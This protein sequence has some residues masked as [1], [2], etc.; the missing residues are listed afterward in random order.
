MDDYTE[1]TPEEREAGRQMML[2]TYAMV[3]ALMAA[4]SDAVM[5]AETEEELYDILNSFIQEQIND[6]TN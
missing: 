1:E 2:D 3:D 4:K 6:R 5:A